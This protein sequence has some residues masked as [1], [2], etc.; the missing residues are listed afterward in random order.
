MKPHSWTLNPEPCT[1]NQVSEPEAEVSTTLDPTASRDWEEATGAENESKKAE[2]KPA[3]EAAATPEPPTSTN[4]TLEATTGTSTTPEL[5]AP[6]PHTVVFGAV[7]SSPSL[8]AVN[9]TI[10]S[11]G[12]SGDGAV[13]PMPP[14]GQNEPQELTA[15]TTEGP[16]GGEETDT[17]NRSDF[18]RN[19]SDFTQKTDSEN[20]GMPTDPGAESSLVSEQ[21]DTSEQGDTEV[22]QANLLGW[23]ALAS[24]QGD[25]SVFAG[26]PASGA[27]PSTTLNPE[28]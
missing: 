4:S 17:E 10:G 15:R 18:T 16:E 24:K 2:H 26:S 9:A 7:A 5:T 27:S 13:T 21:E 8:L 12:S 20:E 19:R 3:A 25:T 6:A 23:A 28:P 14:A 11:N 22:E 1:L